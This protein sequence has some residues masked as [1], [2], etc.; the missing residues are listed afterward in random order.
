VVIFSPFMS[1]LGFRE[2]IKLK[3]KPTANVYVC[4]S[5][6][7]IFFPFKKVDDNVFQTVVCK[8]QIKN[9]S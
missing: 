7:V 5:F 3:K 1:D 9:K 2:K 8:E 6:P 4:K